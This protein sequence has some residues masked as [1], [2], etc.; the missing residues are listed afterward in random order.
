MSK[1][2][3]GERLGRNAVLRTSVSAIVFDQARQKV[4]LTR[5]SDNGRWCLP[6]GSMDPGESV[7][8]TC[9]REIL[10]ETG[11]DIQVVRLVG[12]Y[13]TPDVVVEYSDGNRIQPVVFSFEAQIVRGELRL[14][15]ETTAYGYFAADEI[16]TIDLMETNEERILDALKN[17]EAAFVK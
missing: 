8:E 10:E 6:G 14:S 17:C 13:T 3:Q 2:I 16:D 5:R 4:L 7:K 1:L 11:L 9:V 12:V 15:D